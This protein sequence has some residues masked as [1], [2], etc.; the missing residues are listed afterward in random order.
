[1]NTVECNFAAAEVAAGEAQ[2]RDMP[3]G[4]CLKMRS[5]NG[6]VSASIQA[7][8]SQ[9]LYAFRQGEDVV[10]RYGFS[11]E[12]AGLLA[13][14]HIS[15]GFAMILHNIVRGVV[16]IV[17]WNLV[18]G[19]QAP[20]PITEQTLRS[21]FQFGPLPGTGATMMAAFQQICDAPAVAL[22]QEKKG[23][24]SSL[25]GVTAEGANSARPA[26][27]KASRARPAASS[28]TT[29]SGSAARKTKTAPKQPPASQP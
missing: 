8:L 11:T 29:G 1:V 13:D 16:L 21:F 20:I 24:A 25:S 23:S 17:D 6:L 10:S 9:E 7:R 2:W 19:A 5:L 22:G 12:D 15:A 14:E 18:D 3:H 4:V 28:K 27:K 26:K